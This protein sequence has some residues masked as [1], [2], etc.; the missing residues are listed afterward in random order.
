MRRYRKR[1]VEVEAIQF[2]G[3]TAN[4]AE[5]LAEVGDRAAYVNGAPGHMVI[6]HH[7]EGKM[8]V[9]G[10]DWIIKNSRGEFYP[11]AKDYFERMYERA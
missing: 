2:T 7:R 8:V 1:P 10:G 3:S 5:I 9:N 4:V 6:T 11:A